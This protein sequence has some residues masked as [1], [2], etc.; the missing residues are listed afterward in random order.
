MI[1]GRNHKNAEYAETA[2]PR[3]FMKMISWKI[4]HNYKKKL[5]PESFLIKLHASSLYFIK[6][7]F[8]VLVLSLEL[9]VIV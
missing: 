2:D 3:C 1:T 4:P 9:C 7:E 5:E 6:K 8:L